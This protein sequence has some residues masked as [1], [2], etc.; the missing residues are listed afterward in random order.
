MLIQYVW[1]V[2]VLLKDLMN[3]ETFTNAITM[4]TSGTA[5]GVVPVTIIARNV[6]G[7]LPPI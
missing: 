5:F 3:S 6:A 2:L 7:K 1:I 4:G